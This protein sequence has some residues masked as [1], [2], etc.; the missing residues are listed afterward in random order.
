MKWFG[1]YISFVNLSL[2]LWSFFAP[3]WQYQCYPDCQ[4]SSFPQTNQVY[5]GWLTFHSTTC[6]VWQHI[7]STWILSKLPRRSLQQKLGLRLIMISLSPNWC[8]LRHCINLRMSV[9]VVSLWSHM[10][11]T[12]GFLYSCSYHTLRIISQT[13]LDSGYFIVI[14]DGIDW[15]LTLAIDWHSQCYKYHIQ[16]TIR[17]RTSKHILVLLFHWYT[18]INTPKCTCCI[19]NKGNKLSIASNW[20]LEKD[21]KHQYVWKKKELHSFH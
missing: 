18:Y 20:I 21:T 9:E 8:F 14:I 2:P 19:I 12:R 7:S 10:F 16:S 1:F 13:Y 4:Q 6:F 11:P 15:A 3:C 17:I 5:W